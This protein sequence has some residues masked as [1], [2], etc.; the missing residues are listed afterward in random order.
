MTRSKHLCHRLIAAALLALAAATFAA[1]APTTIGGAA[2]YVTTRGV[3]MEPRFHG[4]DMAVI[5]RSGH[6][7]VGDVVAFHSATLDEVV[8]HRI[9]ARDGERYVFQGDNNDWVDHD[10]PRRNQLVGKLWLRVP[11]FGAISD[12]L[13]AP[14]PTAVLLAVITSLVLF[15]RNGRRRR[16]DRRRGITPSPQGARTVARSHPL[17]D[18]RLLL[19]PSAVAAVAFLGLGV[20]AATNPAT[21]AVTVKTPYTEHVQLGYEARTPR[22]AVYP[23]GLL[24]TGDPIFLRLARRLHVK[25]E[26]RLATSAPHR[27]SGSIGVIAR[28]TSPNGWTRDITLASPTAFTGDRAGAEVTLHMARLRSLVDRVQRLT[29]ASPGGNYTVAVVPRVQLAGTLGGKPLTGDFR[30]ALSFEVDDLQMK[31]GGKDADFSPSRKGTVAA[32][33]N[34]PSTLGVGPVGLRVATAR[35]IALVG[36]LLA[37]AGLLLGTLARRRQPTA[38]AT[39]INARY[40]HLIVPISAIALDPA[41]PPIDVTSMDALV[42][43]AERSERLIL[44]HHRGDGDTYLIDDEGT[45]YRYQAGVAGPRCLPQRHAAAGSVL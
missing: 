2:S 3:S 42:Q 8:M 7:R 19:V 18:A 14:A 22:G 21:T 33:S 23:D 43:L 16:R 34:V 28:L 25:V 12:K 27:L 17:V 29:G 24:R 36:L 26:Y 11:R 30:P 39:R 4:G 40:G 9:I 5:R 10:R 15:V 35:W 41:R 37:A 31:P 6:Y 20:L 45:L 32:P 13:H 38:P 44:H 1:L